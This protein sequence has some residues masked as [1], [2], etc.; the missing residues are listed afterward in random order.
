[1][2]TFSATIEK[3]GVNPYVLLPEKILICLFTQ[4]GKN[5]GPIPV[6]G[7]INRHPFIQHLVKYSGSWRLYLNTPMRKG[8]ATDVGDRV[9]V[10]IEF[11]PEERI[12]PMHPQ[13]KTALLKDKKA[14]AVFAALT[15]SLQKEICRYINQLK[16]TA[17]VEKNIIKA[18]QF[19]LGKER[20]VGRE[21][22]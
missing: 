1:M 6:K 16:T 8:S 10:T 20:F 3:I 11:D 2:Q 15:P 5:K 19:L 9:L 18:I 14:A 12:T 13:L 21:R 17:S 22:P 4:A 7:T